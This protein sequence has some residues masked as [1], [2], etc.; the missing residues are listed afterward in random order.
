MTGLLLPVRSGNP[1]VPGVKWAPM[2]LPRALLLYCCLT[3]FVPFTRPLD[4]AVRIWEEDVVLPTYRLDPPDPNPMFYRGEAYQGAQKRIYPYPFQEHV[5]HTREEK[6]YRFVFLENEYIKL[7]IVPELGGRLFSAVDKANGYDFFYRQS[8]IKPALIGMLGAWISGGIEWCVFHHHRNTTFMPVDYTLAENPDGSKTIWF[9]ETERR[10]RMRWL[11]GVTL[12]PGRSYIETTVKLFNRTPFAHSMLYWANVA[13]HSNENYQ[14]IFPPSVR[15]ATYHA[16]NEFIHWPVGQG[17]YQ[18]TD[19]RNVDLSW[20]K[21][22]PE[23][24]SF[25]AWDLKEDFMGGYD[26]GRQAGVVHVAD[27]H[28]VAGAKLW[29][30]GPGPRGRTW[31]RILTD[32][33]GPYAELMV[34]AYS[35]NQPDYSWIAPS[36]VRIFKQYWYPVREL[37]GFK[38]ANLD[39]AAN[40]EVADGQIR[41]GFNATRELTGAA[42]RLTHG[43][44]V[45]ADERAD[46]DPAHPLVRTLPSP[47]GL[48]PTRLRLELRDASGRLLMEYSPLPESA[49]PPLPEPVRPPPP[50]ESIQTVEELYLTGL[51][52]LQIYNP[53]LDPGAYFA[54]A[55]KRDPDDVRTNLMVGIGFLQRGLY[56]EAERHLERSLGRLTAGYTRP[57]DAEAAYYLGLAKRE[58]GKLDEAYDLLY[59]A[60]WDAGFHAPAYQQ[61]AELSALRGDWDKALEQIDRSLAT[62]AWNTRARG[63]RAAFLRKLGR[64][65]EAAAT[66]REALAEDPLDFLARNELLQLTPLEDREEAWA[67]LRRLMRDEVESY[68]ELGM[69]Y[70]RIGMW[71]EGIE[72]LQRPEEAKMPFASTYPMLYY[73]LAWFNAQEGDLDRANRVLWRASAALPDYCFPFRLESIRVLRWATTVNPADARAHHYLGN[74]LYE[75]QPD[76]AIASWETARRIDPKFAPTA[77]NLGWAYYYHRR[78]IPAAI[79]AYEEAV[80]ADPSDPRYFQELDRLYEAGN[81]APER[82]VELLERNRQ[83]VAGR[84]GSLMRAIRANIAAGR[85]D[86]AVEDLETTFFHIREGDEDIHDLFADAHLLEGL[87]LLDQGDAEAALRHFLRAAEYPE[88]LSVGVPRRDPRAAQ[89]AWTTAQAYRALGQEAK[90]REYLERAASAPASRGWHEARFYQAMALRDLGQGGEADRI[91]AE[92]EQQGNRLLEAE[93]EPDFFAKFGERETESSRLARAHFVRALARWVRQDRAGAKPELERSLGLNQGNAWV[94]YFL[95]RAIAG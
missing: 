76:A 77:R 52:L 2:H 44:A 82:R 15:V 94:R 23:P 29:E 88:N 66:A 68:L 42:V 7:S 73:D 24:I 59:R 1:P 31:D 37:G 17:T 43:D 62:N 85:F 53:S 14:V 8:V 18:G 12:Y 56:A 22:H 26:H 35:D 58:L 84:N 11:I 95:S 80:A 74:L 4:A 19:Y 34:G 69:D 28:I 40:L 60:S 39:A 65:E 87:R 45:L 79:A 33:D 5:T 64:F 55:L 93:P 25:F 78:D 51:R 71:K 27:H 3:A 91:A 20:W 6:T 46:L 9:G 72:V 32:T 16:K 13:V 63:Y 81:V 21:N 54:E 48:Q 92:L 61:L 50:P 49:P 47:A 89:I 75:L 41:F 83:V 38:R 90:A 70:A 57:R 10:H 36:E 30:W 86:R 67:E